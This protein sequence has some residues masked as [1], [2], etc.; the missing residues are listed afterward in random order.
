LAEETA[1]GDDYVKW[2]VDTLVN[3]FD[4]PAVRRLAG[5]DLGGSPDRLEAKTLF[6]QAAGEMG[7]VLPKTEAELRRAYLP[8]L[9]SRLL[10]DKL[11]VQ[12]A[13]NQIHSRIVTPLGHPTDL[14]PWCFLWEGLD[15][16]KYTTLD[17]AE[18]AQAARRL[19]RQALA[20]PPSAAGGGGEVD[21]MPPSPRSP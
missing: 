13:L 21:A 10:D 1:T 15:P 16:I 5:L 6:R 8:I 18:I 7:L 9:A 14:M 17:E 2:A 3:G 4:S 12:D 19:A 11:P 20:P